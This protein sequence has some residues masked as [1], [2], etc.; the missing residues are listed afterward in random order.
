MVTCWATLLVRCVTTLCGLV[1]LLVSQPPDLD[2]AEAAE[3]DAPGAELVLLPPEPRVGEPE[4]EPALGPAWPGAAPPRP[5]PRLR[6]AAAP[7]VAL[8]RR[9]TAA[10]RRVVWEGATG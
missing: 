7:A 10:S 9:S 2:P 5:T 1:Q 3:P 8:R 4:P 6:T